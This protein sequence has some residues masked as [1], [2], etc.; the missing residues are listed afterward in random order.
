MLWLHSTLHVFSVKA[1]LRCHS[2]DFTAH[3]IFTN[4]LQTHHMQEIIKI[5][6]Q[7]KITLEMKLEFEKSD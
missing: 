1:L 3:F 6:L 5:P 4:V 2:E 7:T